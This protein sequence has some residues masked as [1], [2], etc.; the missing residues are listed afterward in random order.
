MKKPV[1]CTDDSGRD[2][3]QMFSPACSWARL[4]VAAGLSA[5][6]AAPVSAVDFK[7]GQT[8]T[9]SAA[10]APVV[11]IAASET[12]TDD[13]VDALDDDTDNNDGVANANQSTS[14]S[15]DAIASSNTVTNE[16]TLDAGAGTAIAISATTNSSATSDA[17]AS[18]DDNTAASASASASAGAN[19]QSDANSNTVSNSGTI[20]GARGIAIESN[21]QATS[22]ATADATAGVDGDDNGVGAATATA[23]ATAAPTTADAQTMSNT[24]ENSGSIAT[25]TAG[26]VFGSRATA[27]NA[28]DAT[29]TA[30]NDGV[31]NPGNDAGV[32]TSASDTE[33]R[34]Q[35]EAEAHTDSNTFT[36][37][38]SIVVSG[39]G[40][41]GVDFNASTDNADSLTLTLDVSRAT[42]DSNTFDNSG[43]I[44]AE[45]GTGLRL[46][47]TAAGTTNPA[48]QES[49]SVSFNTLTNTGKLYA[50]T[51]GIDISAHSD[52]DS[53][54]EGNTINNLYRGRI[55]TGGEGISITGNT[56]LG[57]ATVDGNTI[58][59]SGL[60]V[61]DPGVQISNDAITRSNPAVA[62]GTVMLI[63]GTSRVGGSNS[64]ILEAPSYFAGAFRFDRDANVDVTLKSGVSHSNL[65]TFVDDNA[66]NLGARSFTLTGPNP[67]FRSNGGANNPQDNTNDRFATIDPTAFSAAVNQLADLSGMA[68]NLARQGMQFNGEKNGL[69]VAGH[70]AQLDYNGDN[71]ATADQD[72]NLY[73]GAAGYTHN[74]ERV[75]VAI[76]GG[77]SNST[78]DVGT[79][80]RDL[81]GH[82][83]NN[84]AR[85]GFGG[86]FAG[87][88]LAGFTVDVGVAGGALSHEDHRFVNDNTQWWGI[89]N[90]ESSYDSSWYSAG[91]RVGLPLQVSATWKITP[92]V[93]YRHAW[94]NIDGY[95]ETG[96]NGNEN[97]DIRSRDLSIGEVKV[98]IDIAKSLEWAT[99]A[100]HGGYM[101]RQTHGDNSVSVSMIGDTQNV[102]FFQQQVDAPFAGLDLNV[103]LGKSV[104]FGL[105]GNYVCSGEVRGGYAVGSL[106]FKF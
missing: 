100:L 32:T 96:L 89:A 21:A 14:A 4:A 79:F 73:G 104:D 77:Y 65:W 99:V 1:F 48:G 74:F 62:P 5:M 66:G 13:P 7:V 60:I 2:S 41:I 35:S 67:W 12:V 105:S 9:R 31:G 28:A 102:P 6:F 106:N 80:Y 54:I 37:T 97:A 22:S 15:S 51:R 24:V 49:A 36:N 63:E 16:G 53:R 33:T 98:G 101:T 19:A 85:G 59:N 10:G 46:I 25:T 84:E 43:L 23:T 38:G 52:D 68:F 76:M 29:A 8:V 71:R 45:N 64:V 30:T 87:G 103:P 39:P 70:G 78:L 56:G 61:S 86:L 42:V 91:I 57:E 93:D 55:V 92:N 18:S 95:R 47:A 88:T 90:A 27:G 75:R 11:N 3:G 83:W 50:L 72:T 26:V 34:G 20:A 82:S 17:T 81:Y 69:W 44:S 94:Q 58:R 40:G